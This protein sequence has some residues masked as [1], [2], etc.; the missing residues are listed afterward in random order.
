[1]N[2]FAKFISKYESK[3]FRNSIPRKFFFSFKTINYQSLR[4]RVIFLINIDLFDILK[5]HLSP[6]FFSVQ[7]K[8]PPMSDSWLETIWEF[9]TS[10]GS[11]L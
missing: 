9:I 7:K 3:F 2:V 11:P 6:Y 8:D 10:T 5:D 1:M 4:N